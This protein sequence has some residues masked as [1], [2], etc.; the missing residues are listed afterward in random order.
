MRTLLFVAFVAWAAA[1]STQA[2]TIVAQL[3]DNESEAAADG[4]ARERETPVGEKP[5]EPIVVAEFDWSGAQLA[6]QLLAEL[7]RDGYGCAI[8]RRAATPD[9]AL[10]AAA[11]GVI[12][13]EDE[14]QPRR[15]LIVAPG[16]SERLARGRAGVAVGALLYGGAE[17]SGWFTPQWLAAAHPEIHTLADAA[18][19]PDVFAETPGRRPRLYLCPARW[20]CARDNEQLVAALGLSE[21]F[22]LV[23][24]DSGE[25]LTAALA[26]A[27]A[28]RRPWLGYYWTPSA[29]LA[30]FPMRRLEVGDVELC[31]GGGDC[32]APFEEPA[33]IVAFSEALDDISPRV[34]AMLRRFSI[35]EELTLKTL[36]WKA[37]NN[38]SDEQTAD[39]VFVTYPEL[40]REWLDAEAAERF[41]QTLVDGAADGD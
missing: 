1:G 26:N 3:Q 21:R 19:R 6:A 38:A 39:H 18:A 17:A 27:F 11:E 37:A 35:S 41:A 10:A 5:C 7:V 40:W 30:S 2:R 13:D 24:P 16:V 15:A 34:A 32:R 36:L 23:R 31:D 12:W 28:E 14:D 33:A 20:R 22:D 8:E 4:A 25:A 29:A 9:R